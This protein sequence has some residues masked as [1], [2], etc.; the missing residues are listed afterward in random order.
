MKIILI[1]GKAQHGKT[2]TAIILEKHMTSAGKR[3]VRISFA[4][5]VK[6]IC[7]KYYGWDGR[8]DENGRHLLQYIG[9]D[10]FRARDENF[11]VDNV[12][13]FARV[14]SR[15]YDFMLIDDWRFINEYTRWLENGITDLCRV[16]V[17]RP[18]Y[19]NGLTAEQNNHPSETG[20]DEFAM[21]YKLYAVD[22]AGLEL[23]CGKI[24][25]SMD[26]TPMCSN[27]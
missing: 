21:D 10:V 17:Y 9:T 26:L 18:G 7:S 23:E 13:R 5:Y 11:W 8:K 15:D 14:V 22:L 2:S 24:L 19:D 1:S 27:P 25:A 16:R 20:L 3:A 6:Y 12:I 4:D